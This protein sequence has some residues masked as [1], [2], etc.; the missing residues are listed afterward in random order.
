MDATDSFG[1]WVRRRRKA[2]DLTQEDLAQRVGCA[3]VTLRKIESDQRRPSTQMA[4]RLAQCLA[5]PAEESAAFV[6]AAVGERAPA[7][8][9]SPEASDVYRPASHLPAPVTSLV[10][11]ADEMAAI[12]KAL[13][14][15]DARL[16]TLTGP[17]GVGKTRLA[18]EVGHRLTGAFRDGVCLVAL[19]SV[20]D[21]ALVPSA[22]AS[23]L[24][25]REARDADLAQSLRYFLASREM[26]LIFDN[27]E[28]LLPAVPFLAELL[29]TCPGLRLLATSRA[30]LHLYG[31]H[32][33]ALATLALPE[34]GR[35]MD[36][37]S[38]D[39]IQLF[40][41]RAQAARPGFQLTPSLTPIAIEICRRLDGLP[42]A[43]ELAAAKLRQLT[44][45][46]LVERLER[47]L[48]LL[49]QGS[50]GGASPHQGLHDALAWS[51]GMLTEEERVLLARLAVF[52]DGFSLAAA[53][54]ICAGSV[55]QTAAAGA[56]AAAR[57]DVA[58]GL[59]A[60]LDQSLLMRADGLP[61]GCFA[62]IVCR[63]ACPLAAVLEAVE[64]ESR[65][66]MLGIVREFALEQLQARGELAAMQRRHADYYAAWAMRAAGHLE[67]PGQAVWLARLER[68]ADNLRAALAT[69]LARGPLASAAGMACA[70]GLF[71]QRRGHYSEARGWLEE[72]LAQIDAAPEATSATLRARVMQTAACLAYRQGDWQPARQWLAESLTIYQAAADQPGMARVLFDQGWIAIDQGAWEEAARLNQASLA[73]ARRVDDA[74]ALYRALTNLGW[75]RLSVGAWN[76]AAA[77]F[78][79]AYLLAQRTGHVKGVAVALVN[80]GW[81]AL[82][83]GNMG[84]AACLARHSLCV[85]HLLGEQEVL[86]E[87]LEVLAAA[88]AAEGDASRALE[89]SRAA[90]ALWE[91]L[92]VIHPPTQQAAE[93]HRRA[94]PTA[95]RAAG[96]TFEAA[97]RQDH[98]MSLDAVVA[99]ALN[100]GDAPARRSP[101]HFSP[102]G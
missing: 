98:A 10:G 15:Q 25:V 69:L 68:D 85:C 64:A 35:P 87:C 40:C 93:C 34:R 77:L 91:A 57:F 59:E 84:R 74:V 31:E 13:Q 49:S 17:V 80:Q 76:A 101:L 22:T 9:P 102:T 90:G 5:L 63:G 27:L 37:A 39:A 55:G 79:E 32:E 89:L 16:V 38:A 82:H 28:H 96:G 54:A 11:R 45:Q 18:L 42:L 44:P 70:L 48:P 65:F 47:P 60:L 8:L 21:P 52:T 6:A 19:S 81:V 67:G 86:A 58:S 24:G 50:V 97:T 78:N 36:L 3:V 33:F 92:H 53:E 62:A 99:F 46:E 88:A 14:G 12:A 66:A 41:D 23:A 71:W 4:R 100:C 83:R 7:R 72:A 20:Q 30:R 1:Y 73:L 51:Y 43:I 26:L 2:L 61:P 94:R 95:R 29:A 75:A 56:G